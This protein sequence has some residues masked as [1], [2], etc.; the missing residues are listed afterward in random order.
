VTQFD[1]LLV[2]F[3][4]N[5]EPEQEQAKDWTPVYG[6]KRA[7]NSNNPAVVEKVRA[8]LWDDGRL[9]VSWQMRATAGPNEGRVATLQW[10][11]GPDYSA[12]VGGARVPVPDIKRQACRRGWLDAHALIVSRLKLSAPMPADATEEAA[13]AWAGEAVGKP[14]LIE[15]RL[16]RNGYGSI[17][18]FRNDMSPDYKGEKPYHYR[19]GLRSPEEPARDAKGVVPGVTAADQAKAALDK[20]TGGV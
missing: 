7:P 14:V 5:V 1:D 9:Q 15:A 20:L 10:T 17:A 6:I 12:K 11:L 16:D 4:P 19:I 18:L 13:A 2:G 3:D 8:K